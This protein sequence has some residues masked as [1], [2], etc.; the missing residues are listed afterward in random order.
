VSPVNRLK[1][2]EKKISKK[3]SQGFR[4]GVF[5]IKQ[6]FNK[7]WGSARGKF[8]VMLIPHTEK[9]PFNFQISLFALI[10]AGFF[11]AAIIGGFFVYST[12]ITQVTQN[13]SD[14]VIDLEAA[15]AS[16]E[17]VRK[18]IGDL[19]KAAKGFEE[20]LSQTL[21]VLGIDSGK[22]GDSP[23]PMGDLSYFLGL[24]EVDHGSMPEITDL[25][26]LSVYL[27]E[28]S[29]PLEE[30]GKVL[31]A[32]KDLLVDIPTLWPVQNGIGYVTHE[33]G[34]RIHPFT[35]VW[36]LH[37]GIDIAYRS[38]IP[39]LATANGKIV[40]VGYDRGGYGNFVVIKH[41]YGFY[42]KYAHMDRTTVAKGQ[43]VHRGQIIG[44]MGNTGQ[45]T[46]PHIHYEVRLG[47]QVVDP[48]KYMNISS[49]IVNN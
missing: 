10:F 47:T 45:S 3:T 31:D 37:K 2:T 20:S 24:D 8:T 28:A 29:A 17:T 22:N 36:Y 13:L 16:L 32:Q 33:F 43:E 40:D 38:G 42:T 7:L 4:G 46:G 26:N 9:K 41:Q 21:G 25:R 23:V 35:G 1:Q 44:T 48:R 15:E 39:L 18:E 5:Y 6:F 27:E 34:P 12:E 11:G 14:N 19:K 49:S 30:I